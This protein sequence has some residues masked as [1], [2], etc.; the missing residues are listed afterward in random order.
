[1]CALPLAAA[2]VPPWLV[3]DKTRDLRATVRRPYIPRH[4]TQATKRVRR[5]R[6]SRACASQ[7][8]GDFGGDLVRG[9]GASDLKGER[10]SQRY[11]YFGATLFYVKTNVTLALPVDTVRR[12]KVLAAQ[13]G[14]SISRMLTEQVDEL[15]D[16]ESRYERARRHALADLERGWNL[17]LGDEVTWTRDEL[18]ER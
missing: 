12:L 16:R 13:R 4:E 3:A 10:L 5:C 11:T 18:H 7:E 8:P 15:L 9:K 14:S 6:A 17:G 2:R 1:V